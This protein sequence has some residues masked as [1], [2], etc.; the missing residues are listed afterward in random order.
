LL[1]DFI[2][3]IVTKKF[4]LLSSDNKNELTK[5]F[6]N[7]FSNLTSLHYFWT[8]LKI[9]DKVIIAKLK[10]DDDFYKNH[11]NDIISIVSGNIII[12]SIDTDCSVNNTNDEL[13]IKTEKDSL[14]NLLIEYYWELDEIIIFDTLMNWFICVNHNFEIIIYTK[15]HYSEILEKL[16]RANKYGAIV[17]FIKK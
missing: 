13:M 8:D 3:F 11:I 7:K 2:Q 1:N 15:F 10:P 4:S 6:L 12:L 17:R 9:N 16:E 5:L 14:I